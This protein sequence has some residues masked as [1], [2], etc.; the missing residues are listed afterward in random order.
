MKTI[1]YFILLLECVVLLQLLCVSTYSKSSV[2]IAENDTICGF[3]NLDDNNQRSGQWTFRQGE[4]VLVE[5]R[6]YRHGFRQGK[7]Y[8]F[9][10]PQEPRVYMSAEFDSGVFDG[11]VCFYA[12]DMSIEQRFVCVN[13][14]IVASYGMC[15]YVHV[16]GDYPGGIAPDSIIRNR[17]NFENVGRMA[18]ELFENNTWNEADHC[19][20]NELIVG[21]YCNFTKKVLIVSMIV[22]VLLSLYNAFRHKLYVILNIMLPCLVLLMELLVY[23]IPNKSCVIISDSDTIVGVGNVD[24]DFQRSGIWTFRRNDGHI[25]E[26][27]NYN[28]GRMDGSVALENQPITSIYVSRYSNLINNIEIGIVGVILL[29]NVVGLFLSKGGENKSSG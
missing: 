20:Y 17:P 23:K 27:H 3:G 1:Q 29:L 11:D 15:G 16:D 28:N 13:D 19:K 25:A 4:G 10:Y 26:Q 2:L 21:R 18:S 22:I 8:Y 7:C 14:T 6:N 5:Q 12:Q 24:S 9:M